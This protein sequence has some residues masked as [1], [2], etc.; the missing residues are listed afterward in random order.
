MLPAASRPE[1]EVATGVAAAALAGIVAVPSR[2][3]EGRRTLILTRGAWT[4]EVPLE[5][6][7]EALDEAKSGRAFLA[8]V[9]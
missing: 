7:R 3:E 5:Q 4:R 2:S 9:G 6:L 1:K 8:A